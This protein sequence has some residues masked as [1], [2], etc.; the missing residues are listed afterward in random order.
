MKSVQMDG[1]GS[2]AR[3]SRLIAEALVLG[4]DSTEVTERAQAMGL[5]KD[6]THAVV[7]A[8][9]R[10]QQEAESTGMLESAD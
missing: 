1:A 6:L 2:Q 7:C 8:C 10:E 9:C 5:S 3:P 4:H